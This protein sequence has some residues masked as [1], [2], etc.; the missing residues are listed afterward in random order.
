MQ[1]MIPIQRTS[2]KSPSSEDHQV[3]WRKSKTYL[4]RNICIQAVITQIIINLVAEDLNAK[5]KRKEM[6]VRKPDDV[7]MLAYVTV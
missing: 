6:K 1:Q 5:K 3:T 2:V 7:L 4:W